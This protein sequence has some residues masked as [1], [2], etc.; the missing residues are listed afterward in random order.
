LTAPSAEAYLSDLFLSGPNAGINADC[1]IRVDKSIPT[2]AGD[3][4]T[5]NGVLFYKV[6]PSVVAPP[7]TAFNPT[8]TTSDKVNTLISYA[9]SNPAIGWQDAQHDGSPYTLNWE[10]VTTNHASISANL[11][12]PT[13]QGA[14]TSILNFQSASGR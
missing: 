12:L 1:V 2:V 6:A 5:L 13:G 3:S 8:T 14:A 9:N 4:S 7:P 11:L 10:M